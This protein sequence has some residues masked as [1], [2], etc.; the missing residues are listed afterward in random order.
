[1]DQRNE[2]L[3]HGNVKQLLWQYALPAI[4]A[5]T[6]TSF[7]NIIDRIFIGQGVGPLAIS[8]LALTFPIM[9]LG[10]ALGT[11]V[12]AGSSAIISIRMG[13]KRRE[14]AIQ[15][16]GNAFVLNMIIGILFSVLALCFLDPL[17][18]LF[19]ASD[20]TLPFARDF[21]RVIL[22]GNV[23]THLFFGLNNII[24]ASGYPT[25]A[26][27]SLLLTIGINII[28]AP[29]FIFV[30]HWGI[31]GAA[32]ATVISQSAGLVWVVSHFL[33]R[34]PYVHFTKQ[35]FRLSG[36]IIGSIFSIGVA[37][38]LIHC[39]ACLIAIL[40]NRQLGTYGGD[41]AIGAFGIINSIISLL[42]MIMFGF[43]QGMQP[44]VGYNWG[45]KQ[46]DRAIEAFRLTIYYATAV[47]VIGFIAA[48]CFPG[49]IARWFTDSQELIDITTKG[50]RIYVIC[51]SLVGFQV[52]TTNFFQS[53]GKAGISIF[54]SM[55]RQ[56]LFLTPLL[57]LFPPLFGLDGVWFATPAAD[58][59]AALVTA[60]VLWYYW[61]KL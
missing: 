59:I 19:G 16:L 25:K 41:M 11:L 61:Q 33:S 43:T 4:I 8:G 23:I 36:R 32:T 48:E 14:E 34:K 55:T 9:N 28:L 10:T 13:E 22:L 20:A 60:G 15:T 45:A 42:I 12:G 31:K 24:R 40:M 29:L 21:M 3:E 49:F 54:L 57:L 6:A 52:V 39:C 7:Y 47:S 44:I 53:I 2:A 46:H 35:C 51:L 17:L 37:P 30:F 1:M 56:L 5:T 50:M 26:M 58:L 38:F 27:I 18:Y